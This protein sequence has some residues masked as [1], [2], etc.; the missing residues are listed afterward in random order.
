MDEGG[1]RC[2]GENW[3]IGLH[4][5]AN[6]RREAL[7]TG[8][9]KLAERVVD[10][11]A[12]RTRWGVKCKTRRV[13]WAAATGN[14][15]CTDYGTLARAEEGVRLQK[16]GAPDGTD[17]ESDT[18]SLGI[19]QLSGVLTVSPKEDSGGVKLGG[20]EAELGGNVDAGVQAVEARGEA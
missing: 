11:E 6:V 7:V 12:R 10:G 15:A 4:A 9:M 1:Y 16:R 17:V 19:G 20:F 18:K 14:S 5:A 2:R 13:N 3:T 8:K